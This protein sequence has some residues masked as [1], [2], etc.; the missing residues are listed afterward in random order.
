MSEA[1]ASSP[2]PPAQTEEEMQE[3]LQ[4]KLQIQ[5][6]D[7]SDAVQSEA[8]DRAERYLSEETTQRGVGGFL[9]KIWQGNIAR[10]FYR[11]RE[12]QRGRRE[13]VET[14][15]IYINTDGS[16]AD[17]DQAMAAVVERFTSDFVHEGEN[18]QQFEDV[19]HGQELLSQL[20]ELV[21]TYASGS[22]DHDVLVEERTR[23]L[24]EYGQQ[25]HQADRNRG[26]VYADNIL[27]V[28]ANA[29]TAFEHGAG[30]DRLDAAISGRVGE[31]RTGVRTEAR[32][33]A[34]DRAI[35]WM[36]RHH[37]SGVNETTLA[38]GVATAMTAAKFTTRKAATA[39]AA[40]AGLGVGAGLIAA[41]REH[42][43]VGQ[44]RTS[45]SRQM[46]EG[47]EIQ[48]NSQRRERM[49]E[50]RY[51]TVSAA[52]LTAGLQAAREAF[53]A[54][55]A[56]SLDD[57][58]A[59]ATAA[60]ARIHASD[61]QSIDLLEYSAKASVET[62]RLA[63][64]I[65]LAR[66][67]V[68]AQEAVEANGR[69]FDLDA[70]QQSIHEQI[71]GDIGAKDQAFSRLRRNRTIKMGLIGAATGVLA[72]LGIQEIHSLLDSGL[73]GVAE[74][75][76]GSDRH[77][78]LADLFRGHAQHDG[79][80]GSNR[81]MFEG[82]QHLHDYGVNLPEGYHLVQARPGEKFG[83]DI[84]GP[85]GK[86]VFD[87]LDLHSLYN[88][89]DT[90][91]N[92]IHHLNEGQLGVGFDTQ[93]N[94]DH[95]TRMALKE[96]GF[97]LT[98][99]HD[100]Q[101]KEPTVVSDSI[102]RSPS[103]Y[104]SHHPGQ[105]TQVHR[106]LWYDN[107][108]PG[109]YDQNE[110]KLWWGGATGSGIDSHG[111]YVFNVAHMN[112]DG[113]Y[114]QGL[115]TDAQ[116][117][118][119]DGKMKLALSMT[120]DTQS[121]VFM[122]NVDSNGNAV[123]PHDS[124]IG[125][126]LFENQNGHA[127]FT[128]A[129]AEADQ[130]LGTNPDGSENV[131]MLATVVGDN[132][133]QPA[134]DIIHHVVNQEHT[135]YVTHI[136]APAETPI[137]I[138]AVLPIYSRRGLESLSYPVSSKEYYGGYAG[139]FGPESV[140][141]RRARAPFAPELDKDPNAKIDAKRV[142]E[143][144]F[145]G[146][147]RRY[148]ETLSGLT[149]QLENQPWANNPKIVVMIPAAAHQEGKNIYRSLEQYSG[150]KGVDSDDYEIV[151]FANNPRVDSEGAQVQRDTTIEEIER[152]QK[153]HPELRVRY[154]ERTLDRQEA[155]IGKIRKLLA[156]TVLSDLLSRGVD[157]DSVVLTSNDADSEWIDPRYIK[158]IIDKAE[159][160]PDTDGFL[161]FLD[162][163]YDAYRAHP[164][165]L[166]GTRLMQMMD[167]YLRIK[168]KGVGSSGANFTFRPSIY[169]AV[170]GYGNIDKGE[171]VQLGRMIRGVRSGAD[172]RRPIGFLGR[173]S[174]VTTSSRRALAK[175]LKDGGAP[176][177]Q[178]EDA[179]TPFDDLRTRDFK[180]KD[181]N[182]DDSSGVR[183]LVASTEKMINAT[184]TIYKVEFSA[185]ESPS[186][187]AG[188]MTSYDPESQRNL[189]RFMNV[190]GIVPQWQPDGTIKIVDAK[191]MLANLKRWQTEH[192]G[193]ERLPMFRR[194]GRQIR[195]PRAVAAVERASERAAA[196][197][198]RS[199]QRL[200]EEIER[201]RAGRT[202]RA[203]S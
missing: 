176:I 127:H 34:T 150:Q 84:E 76:A 4:K 56:E 151:V 185:E 169:M 82:G 59:V 94:L 53:E 142:A 9:K 91:S 184:L 173:S 134:T 201:F 11:Q 2:P 103:E 1:I 66:A 148:T 55:D 135:H 196:Y 125:H 38:L 117:L 132:N 18:N 28:A 3:E 27:E 160:Q 131:R 33:Q 50:T 107:N 75:P 83:W 112:P 17:H 51:E 79:T 155:N 42:L 143:R 46:A 129:Y 81:E 5:V 54:G 145:K 114:H 181:F 171:D 137:E 178:W 149:R 19:E 90:N 89:D 189:N 31:A 120:K 97:K 105:F 64:D 93:G 140:G 36:H 193:R 95:D 190:I 172:S 7:T 44:E 70:L 58:I 203:T 158:T 202:E 30:L 183:E 194:E 157:L 72:G 136:E 191:R 14:G 167:S 153:E 80:A 60:R 109:V 139:S 174:E 126:S 47:G 29:R 111:D 65:E 86:N 88:S 192:G 25:V 74:G 156:D 197:E 138:P 43:R 101:F 119:H 24:S 6:V 21:S 26:L 69:P 12:I 22:I 170:G 16:Q 113:S 99:S 104:L 73:R 48:D 87:K 20:Q 162:W 102:S 108:T 96:L 180:L 23:I 128:G 35:D 163:S 166:V 45:H 49:E 13:I 121:N 8:V 98:Q 115:L 199:R 71:V 52:D 110:L 175:A 61:V 62:E 198:A 177:E 147:S 15:N 124:F 116:Q 10:D 41:G 85:D 195:L 133:P 92:H 146:L 67:T 154:I 57:L 144:Y 123:I 161:G 37:M 165:Q 152:F 100:L 182:F 63:L 106:E 130:I 40:V 187:R 179:F 159:A 77:S 141:V 32:L 164:E 168:T 118:V 188:R 122:V 39:A 186:Y 78:L 200:D 68:A